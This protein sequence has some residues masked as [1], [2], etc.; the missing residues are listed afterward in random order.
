MKRIKYIVLSSVLAFS[1]LISGCVN[2]YED[3]STTIPSENNEDIRLV[4]TSPAIAEI[5]DKLEL[6]AVGICDT[7]FEIPKRY[8]NVEKIGYAMSPDLEIVKS[9]NPDYVLSPLTLIEDLQPKYASIQV[10]SLFLNLK[11]VDGLYSAISDLGKILNRYEQAQRLVD[12]YSTFI[13]EYKEKNKDKVAPKVLILMGLPGSYVVATEHSYAGSLVKL[14]GGIN[15]YEDETAEFINANTE[16]MKAK[17]PDI[18]LRTAHA[19]PDRVMEMFAEE[20]ETNDV[21]KHFRAVKEN[22][23]YDLSYERFGMSAKFNYPQALEEL[24]EILYS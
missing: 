20:F 2:Q 22:K 1:A 9:L 14:A 4:I 13:N 23:V 24:Q 7:S 12:E 3:S 5:T 15:V 11:S 21:W 6:E 8:E 16:D 18:I 19:L 10:K 17:D